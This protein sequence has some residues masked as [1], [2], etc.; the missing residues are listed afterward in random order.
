MMARLRILARLSLRNTLRQ[1]RRSALTASAMVVGLALLTMA[2]AIGDGAHEQWIS[3]GV[4]LGLGHVTMEAPGFASTGSLDDRLDSARVA[5]AERAVAGLRASVPVVTSAVDLTVSGL[6]SSPGSSLPV[7]VEGVEPGAEAAFSKL[8]ERRVEGRYLEPS[9]RLAAYVGAGLADRLGLELGSRLVLTAQGASGGVAEQLVRVRGVFR[10]GIPDVDDGLVQIP[11]ATA[12]RWLGT[13]GAATSVAVLLRSSQ[14]TG[15][16]LDG[17]R[18]RLGTGGG[19]DG[20]T[21][22]SWRQVSP[23]LESAVRID[24]FGFY[25]FMVVLF[26]IVALAVLNAVLMSVLNRRREFGVL[27]ALGLTRGQTGAVVFGE[28]V[29]LAGLSGVLGVALGLATTWLLWR[30]GLDLSALYGQGISLSGAVIDPVIVP[31]FRPARV[32]EA[33]GFVVVIGILASLYPTRVATR[34]DVAEALKFDR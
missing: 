30:H 27:E 22:L 9:D 31:I 4:R 5:A 13:P 32:V 17:L 15:R 19:A 10:T 20:V 12:R 7:R 2:R 14:E 6:A 24:D 8:D 1:A 21:V 18:A 23:E 25:A 28:G 29:L 11:I 26:A 33:A 34:I 3:D 16:A